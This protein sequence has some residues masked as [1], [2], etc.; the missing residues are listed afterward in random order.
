MSIDNVLSWLLALRRRNEQQALDQ[1]TRSQAEARRAAE[2]QEVAEDKVL[3]HQVESRARERKELSAL[4]GTRVSPQAILDLQDELDVM[5]A[6]EDRLKAA[7]EAAR[8][9]L[10][11]RTSAVRDAQEAFRARQRSA[12]KLAML[13]DRR[14]RGTLRRQ[15]ALADEASDEAKVGRRPNLTTDGRR[16]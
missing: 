13:T 2:A 9:D 14:A 10:A 3:R 5:A 15:E 7:G 11:E 12:A 8:Q 6:E 4:L 1:L 16:A